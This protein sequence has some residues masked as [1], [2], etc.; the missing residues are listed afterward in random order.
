LAIDDH[1]RAVGVLG[2]PVGG[3]AEQ[4]VAQ[5]VALVAEH[6]Q[7]V[8]LFLSD[9]DDQLG[10]VPGAAE[11]DLQLDAGSGG[12]LACRV[13]Q[14]PEEGVLL[15]AYL[16]DLADRGGVGG[17]RSFDRQRGQLRAG[18]RGQ[19]ECLGEGTVRRFGA[20]DRGQDPLERH[21]ATLPLE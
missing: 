9:A 2:D 8:L 11:L 19:L 5:E 6:D 4:V 15:A 12:L 20:V 17:Q 7:V 1:H 13:E 10:R 18:A 14:A 3:R 21:L 16:V